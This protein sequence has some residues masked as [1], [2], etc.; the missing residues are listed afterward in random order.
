MT[1]LMPLAQYHMDYGDH[2]DDGWG[3][4]MAIAMV[5]IV[6]AA[7]ALIVWVVR[8]SVA[9]RTSDAAAPSRETA[10]DILDRR[11]AAGEITVEEHRQRADVLSAGR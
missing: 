11:L 1:F 5:I 3:W 10:L 8:S 7:V 6:L 4:A 2:M 9:G